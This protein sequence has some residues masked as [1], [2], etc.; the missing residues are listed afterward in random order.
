M[1]LLE[2]EREEE[3]GRLVLE[4]W[5]GRTSQ[6]KAERA[7]AGRAG[8]SSH[9][10]QLKAGRLERKDIAERG[11]ETTTRSEEASTLKLTNGFATTSARKLG[12]ELLGSEDSTKAKKRGLLDPTGVEEWKLSGATKVERRR[13][14]G[15]PEPEA[16]SAIITIRFTKP[17]SIVELIF[18]YV[19]GNH[20]GLDILQCIQK[21]FF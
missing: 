20:F 18:I 3:S 17:M 2:S 8:K 5:L 11:V 16:L 9:K 1:E 15:S 13:L 21:S 4:R 10:Y 12:I 14:P 19:R 6:A 7:S